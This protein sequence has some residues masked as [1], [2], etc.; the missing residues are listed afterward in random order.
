MNLANNLANTKP[1]MKLLE[2]KLS[3]S[4]LC[5]CFYSFE[6]QSKTEGKHHE[7]NRDQELCC[8]GAAKAHQ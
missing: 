5:P 2:S 3:K 4:W 6:R 7:Q 8:V 1:M